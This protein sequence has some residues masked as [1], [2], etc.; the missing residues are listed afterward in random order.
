M[1]EE[2]KPWA[3]LAYRDASAS[4]PISALAWEKQQHLCSS[5]PCLGLCVSLPPFMASRET[6]ALTGRLVLSCTVAMVLR[7]PP[8]YLLPFPDLSRDGD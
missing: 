3:G 6:S 1:S 4:L 2:S 5:H 7:A 8:A